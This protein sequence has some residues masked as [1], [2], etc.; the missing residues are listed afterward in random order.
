MAAKAMPDDH[1]TIPEGARK[2]KVSNN[3]M[4]RLVHDRKIRSVLI[5]RN[6]R[7]PVSALQELIDRG[8]VPAVE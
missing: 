3:T 4:W 5:G 1:L 7:I 8:T 2:I 6:R